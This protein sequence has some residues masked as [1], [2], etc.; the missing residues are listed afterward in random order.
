MNEHLED[1]QQG[2][3]SQTSSIQRLVKHQEWL[4]KQHQ[5]VKNNIFQR[6]KVDDKEPVGFIK[7]N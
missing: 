4:R 1:W 3:D 5:Q 7:L 2:N 6:N